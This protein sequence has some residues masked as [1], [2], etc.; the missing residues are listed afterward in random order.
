MRGRRERSRAWQLYGFK[1]CRQF[2]FAFPEFKTPKPILAE[3][4]LVLV[5]KTVDHRFSLATLLWPIEWTP[6]RKPS[7]SE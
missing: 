2:R 5:V 3:P 6:S 1:C 7:Q 4:R